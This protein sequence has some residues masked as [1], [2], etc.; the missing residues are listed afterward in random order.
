V[1]RRSS[2]EILEVLKAADIAVG[3]TLQISQPGGSVMVQGQ[4]ITTVGNIRILEKGSEEI[5]FLH[6]NKG[7][8]FQ[9]LWGD[10]GMFK[11][12]PT[13]DMVKVPEGAARRVSEF[14][15]RNPIHGEEVLKALRQIRDHSGG[16]RS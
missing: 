3:S 12:D 13:T 9:I 7:R 1:S 6:R 2:V 10:V 15:A 11:V 5:L 4:E 14:R 16:V 8:D